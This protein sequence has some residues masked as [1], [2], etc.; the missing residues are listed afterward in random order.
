[1]FDH[2]EKFTFHEE[3]DWEW[4]RYPIRDL[5]ARETETKKSGIRNR[6]RKTNFK[7]AQLSYKNGFNRQELKLKLSVRNSKNIPDGCTEYISAYT[8]FNASF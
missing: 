2:E 4:T 6:K 5:S 1:M 8:L 3:N 7:I